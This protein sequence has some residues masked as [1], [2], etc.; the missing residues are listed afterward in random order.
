LNSVRTGT[1]RDYHLDN[2][3]QGR[4]NGWVTIS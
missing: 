2:I 4:L 1:S 3:G